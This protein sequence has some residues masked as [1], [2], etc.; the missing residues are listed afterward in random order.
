MAG[1]TAGRTTPKPPRVVARPLK[2]PGK[3]AGLVPRH[4]KPVAKPDPIKVRALEMGY[5]D[6][7]RR[8]EGDVFIIANERAFSARW[9]ERVDLRT[10]EHVTTAPAALRKKHDEILGG[11]VTGAQDVFEE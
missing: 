8:R 5:Y 3:M 11:T 2:A 9:M 1:Q 10:P 6:H 4:P 7:A